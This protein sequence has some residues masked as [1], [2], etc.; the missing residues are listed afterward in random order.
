MIFYLDMFTQFCRN[1]FGNE[2]LRDNDKFDNIYKFTMN[3]N[4][5][6]TKFKTK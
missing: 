5:N 6:K 4:I 3:T 1:R 2:Y